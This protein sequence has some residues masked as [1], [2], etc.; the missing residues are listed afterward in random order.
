MRVVQTGS[1]ETV[2]TKS[3]AVSLR[4]WRYDLRCNRLARQHLHEV[5]LRVVVKVLLCFIDEQ[6]E[7][8]H[9]VCGG[10]AAKC[11]ELPQSITT[12]G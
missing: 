6:D 9:A 7:V 8:L 3:G 10:E 12:L 1:D 4:C 11:N 2:S 5:G